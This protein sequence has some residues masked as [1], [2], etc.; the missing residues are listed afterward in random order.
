MTVLWG[1]LL[2]LSL[3][4]CDPLT[5]LFSF[6]YSEAAWVS[7][8]QRDCELEALNIGSRLAD[9]YNSLDEE[10]EWDTRIHHDYLTKHL[11]FAGWI[12]IGLWKNTQLTALR[13]HAP[14]IHK[15]GGWAGAKN[16]SESAYWAL[17]NRWLYMMG[18]S[19]QRQIW[20][21]FLSP[22]QSNDF[23]RNA[24]E[25]TRENCA[26]QFPHRKAHPADHY[27][28][29][30]GW[31]GRC[32]NNEPS[33]LLCDRKHF[34]YEDYDEWLFGEDGL[35]KANSTVGSYPDILVIH[36]GLHTCVHARTY[37]LNLTMVSKH[38]GEIGRL[39]EAVQRALDRLPEDVPRTTVIFQLPGRAGNSDPWGDSC[40]RIF[41]RLLS[42]Q[43]HQFGF[44]V[45]EREEI[46]RRLLTRSEF[47]I[48][49]RTI[50]NSLHL[51][52]PG[53]NIVGT[54]LLGLISCLARN[55]SLDR[56]L[57]PDPNAV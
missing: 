5:F 19:T 55:G 24:K 30:E 17:E 22:F 2:F 38:L 35:W 41:N 11:G 1:Q 23:E 14:T 15:S 40:S 33:T 49:H 7:K 54:S 4:F 21:T 34:T 37:G 56:P 26:R 45:F 6:T 29:D 25:W 12:Q 53:P 43:S 52:N 32:G 13:Q 44:A 57:L 18:D 16:I 39:M 50:K 8:T 42:Y 31:G 51:D 9:R 3:L 28:P 10:T 46:E 36:V 48:D 27:F 47:Y 20:A